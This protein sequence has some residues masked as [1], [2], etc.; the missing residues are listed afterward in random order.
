M[1]SLLPKLD[2]LMNKRSWSTK[3]SKFNTGQQYIL[4]IHRRCI[5]LFRES[6]FGSNEDMNENL[7]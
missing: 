4:T 1:S 3:K 5:K 7:N 6:S 2:S